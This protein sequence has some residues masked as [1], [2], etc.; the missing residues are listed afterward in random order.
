M[1][2]RNAATDSSDEDSDVDRHKLPSFDHLS[3]EALLKAAHDSKRQLIKAP[4]KADKSTALALYEP[5]QQLVSVNGNAADG[6]TGV[7]QFDENGNLIEEKEADVLPDRRMGAVIGK[8]DERLKKKINIRKG[9][10][11]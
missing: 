3:E 6:T 10:Q 5:Q 9:K 1:T 4:V 7:P 11:S 8:A 2:D